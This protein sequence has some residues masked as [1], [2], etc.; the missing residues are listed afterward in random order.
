MKHGTKEFYLH[1]IPPDDE[2][3]VACHSGSVTKQNETKIQ[4][5]LQWP[6]MPPLMHQVSK[7]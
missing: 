5:V 1:L 2:L 6:C 4:R 3:M 7:Q